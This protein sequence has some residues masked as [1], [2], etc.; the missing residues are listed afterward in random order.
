M[1][2]KSTFKERILQYLEIKGITKYEFYQKTGVSNGTLSQNGGLGEENILKFL[3]YYRDISSDWFLFG[4]GEMFRN[5]EEKPAENIQINNRQCRTVQNNFAKNS[6]SEPPAEYG[7]N[8]LTI[9][10]LYSTIE[11]Q[12][13]TIEA[14]QKLIGSLERHIE[15]L[16][17]QLSE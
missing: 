3:S 15:S 13:H 6:A 1:I 16:E 11:A 5:T 14:Q 2:K 10:S 12:Q 8:Q 9:Q 4:K 17:R 7:N